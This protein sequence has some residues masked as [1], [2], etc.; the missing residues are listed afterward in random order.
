[1]T[2][3]VFDDLWLN[4]F[5][6]SWPTDFAGETF[7]VNR[8]GFHKVAE[9]EIVLQYR[10][11]RVEREIQSG[12]F[13]VFFGEIALQGFIVQYSNKL[14]EIPLANIFRR[15]RRTTPHREIDLRLIVFN[16]YS[17]KRFVLLFVI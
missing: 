13:H 7:L 16:P 3:F 8:I 11:I 12:F 15:L 10:K 5:D 14:V 6:G 17:D 1:M 4:S 2:F 9:I